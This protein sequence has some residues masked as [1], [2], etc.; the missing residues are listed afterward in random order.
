MESIFTNHERLIHDIGQYYLENF[1]L[2]K[3]NPFFNPL[4]TYA[5]PKDNSFTVQLGDIE[6]DTVDHRFEEQSYSLPFFKPKVYACLSG[7]KNMNR[8]NVLTC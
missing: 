3:A 1:I 6:S 2:K 7:S 5:D 4:K 8:Y